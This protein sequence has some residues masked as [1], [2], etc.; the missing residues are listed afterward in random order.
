MAA[1]VEEKQ[2]QRR[3]AKAVAARVAR[4]AAGPGTGHPWRRLILP[5][6]LTSILS[7]AEAEAEAEAAAVIGFSLSLLVLGWCEERI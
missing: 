6:C 4:R 3:R 1:G 2:R 7:M 5:F